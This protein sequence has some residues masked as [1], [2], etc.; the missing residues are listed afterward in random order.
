MLSAPSTFTVSS[1]PEIL[2]PNVGIYDTT[3]E[4]TWTEPKGAQTAELE[5]TNFVTNEVA[6][7]QAGISGTSFT[8]PNG[9]ALPPGGYRARVRSFGGVT[10]AVA[11]DWSTPHV[12]QIGAAPVALGPSEGLGTAPFTQTHSTQ[13]T[14]TAQQSLS[15]VTFEFW[16]SDVTEGQTLF[17]AR[18]LDS[19][20]WTV[21]FRLG[22]G[23][24]RYWV[25]ATT[26]TGERSA[27]SSA[28]N[29]VSIPPPVVNE[30]GSTFNA[31][32]QI[33][34]ECP[35]ISSPKSIRIRCG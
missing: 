13:P 2:T 20:S 32:P 5:I 28:F 8:I 16:L 6:F 26:T 18:G 24:Y 17:V 23:A 11:S 21:P 33:A 31:R 27:W 4:F 3:P 1:P 30:I 12:F 15:G 22:V 35:R 29:F 10:G 25:R 19:P 34:W 9:S 14:L 7:V